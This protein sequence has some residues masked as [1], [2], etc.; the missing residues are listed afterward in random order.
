[1]VSFWIPYNCVGKYQLLRAARVTDRRRGNANLLSLWPWQTASYLAWLYVFCTAS[2]HISAFAC[3]SKAAAELQERV[4]DNRHCY[5]PAQRSELLVAWALLH[6]S[7]HEKAIVPIPCHTSHALF[8][9]FKTPITELMAQHRFAALC[10]LALGHVLRPSFFLQ[11]LKQVSRFRS[12]V[13]QAQHATRQFMHAL[14]R[15]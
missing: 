13:L 9:Y 8:H 4:G 12:P 3:A 10:L 6:H 7:T 1:M 14:Q 15:L 5:S 2:Q 11:V